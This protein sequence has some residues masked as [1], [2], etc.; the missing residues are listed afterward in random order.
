MPSCQY[1]DNQRSVKLSNLEQAQALA[2]QGLIGRAELVQ[3]DSDSLSVVLNR[4]KILGEHGL[5][6]GRD[7]VLGS[8]EL[9]DPSSSSVKNDSFESVSLVPLGAVS[10]SVSEVRSTD[11]PASSVPDNKSSESAMS[12][13][14]SSDDNTS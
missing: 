1:F 13:S 2:D 7:G 3:V 5:S 14:S 9:V 11:S 8:M 4:G 10:C 6:A 12:N